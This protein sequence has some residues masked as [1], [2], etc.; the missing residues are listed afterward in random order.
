VSSGVRAQSCGDLTE[1]R[2]NSQRDYDVNGD[3]FFDLRVLTEHG[4]R[5][6]Y[7]EGIQSCIIDEFR[8]VVLAP[9]GGSQIA[10]QFTDEQFQALRLV[11]GSRLDPWHFPPRLSG[12]S[13]GRNGEGQEAWFN[14]FSQ[15]T[16]YESKSIEF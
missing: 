10:S 1:L 9:L 15:N 14:D 11:A 6:K 2:H 8:S 7:D 5:I 3:G 16:E 13:T 4:R 12:D